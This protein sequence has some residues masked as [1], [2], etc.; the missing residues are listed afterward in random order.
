MGLI[1]TS[2]LNPRDVL[3]LPSLY[4]TLSRRERTFCPLSAKYLIMWLY[5][6]LFII[7]DN[8]PVGIFVYSSFF[9]VFLKTKLKKKKAVVIQCY[10]SK[11][12]PTKPNVGKPL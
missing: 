2:R 9:F 10:D 7:L 5:Q 11:L 4:K 6:Y 3:S 12:E 8:L 1:K